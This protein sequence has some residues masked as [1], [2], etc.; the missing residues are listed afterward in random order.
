MHDLRLSGLSHRNVLIATGQSPWSN[1][2]TRRR[3][4]PRDTRRG[5]FSR[6]FAKR[7]GPRGA[8]YGCGGAF[9][10]GV[11]SGFTVI[12]GGSVLPAG[13][14]ALGSS[15]SGNEMSLSTCSTCDSTLNLR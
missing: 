7:I 13:F 12:C 9:G 15:S 4:R 3:I 14:F 2:R 11:S 1:P 8:G 5:H 6:P 10:F